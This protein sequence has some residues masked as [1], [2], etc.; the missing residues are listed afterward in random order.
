MCV[1]QHVDNKLEFCVGYS[2]GDLS[3]ISTH[4]ASDSIHKPS[5][6]HFKE[7]NLTNSVVTCIVWLNDSVFIV[8]LSDGQILMLD[9]NREDPIQPIDSEDSDVNNYSNSNDIKRYL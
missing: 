6:K 9:K 3:V 5:I 7:G 1:N 2:N 8:G 4:S